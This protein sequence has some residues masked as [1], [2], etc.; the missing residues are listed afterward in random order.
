M[1]DSLL[2]LSLLLELALQRGT[3]SAMLS[4]VLLLLTLANRPPERS[5]QSLKE[6][7]GTGSYGEGEGEENNEQVKDNEL[8]V[9]ALSEVAVVPFLQ[10]LAGVEAEG[11]TVL[12]TEKKGDP[13]KVW[14][15]SVSTRA[16]C[17][18]TKK[19]RLIQREIS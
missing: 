16:Y 4:A 8:F 17:C 11:G 12:L 6:D 15:V 5:A 2:A 19:F 14:S 18:C 1:G 7:Q 3:L 13:T 10:R 9:T